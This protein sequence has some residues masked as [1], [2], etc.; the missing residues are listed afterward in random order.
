MQ[1]ARLSSSVTLADLVEVP[2]DPH[3]LT[4]GPS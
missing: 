2:L 4:E 3:L 1:K